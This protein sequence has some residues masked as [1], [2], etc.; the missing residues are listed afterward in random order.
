MNTKS[1]FPN[2]QEGRSSVV[3]QATSY[4]NG[5][6]AHNHP[7]IRSIPTKY[8]SDM[9][10]SRLETRWAKIFDLL[11][12]EY[13]YEPEIYRCGGINYLPDFYLPQQNIYFEVKGIMTPIDAR[14]ITALAEGT[15]RNVVIG[16]PNGT[17]QLVDMVSYDDN[18]DSN[19]KDPAHKAWWVDKA[20]ST[21]A[22]CSQCHKWHFH[23]E[24]MAWNCRICGTWDKHWPEGFHQGND[25]LFE[26][27]DV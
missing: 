20:D 22:K 26:E 6:P 7:R 12:I 23:N 13:Y 25:N 18:I 11:G 2:Q 5:A 9:M 4:G 10:R 19:E 21:F 15:G 27:Y 3:A 16:Y 17:L 14:K 24:I 1:S 8:K